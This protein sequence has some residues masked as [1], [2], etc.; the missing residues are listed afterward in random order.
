[1]SNSCLGL[2][3][4]NECTMEGLSF[5]RSIV[6]ADTQP[7]VSNGE[8]D[9]LEGLIME[10]WKGN[11]QGLGSNNRVVTT[12]HTVRREQARGRWLGRCDSCAQVTQKDWVTDRKRCLSCGIIAESQNRESALSGSYFIAFLKRQTWIIK[13]VSIQRRSHWSLKKESWYCLDEDT[14]FSSVVTP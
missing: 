11:R 8:S 12:Y 14:F 1:M 9:T 10:L 2:P 3:S 5:Q 6:P 13:T 4:E 7:E